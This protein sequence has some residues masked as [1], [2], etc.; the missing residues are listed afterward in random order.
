M[1]WLSWIMAATADHED[2][3]SDQFHRLGVRDAGERVI[4]DV[5][6]HVHV[7]LRLDL[8]RKYGVDEAAEFCE[9]AL[10]EL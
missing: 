3:L 5:A 10:L 2:P 9:K 1:S 6:Q 8:V 7:Q 4:L